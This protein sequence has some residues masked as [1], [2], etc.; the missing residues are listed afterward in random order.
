MQAGFAPIASAIGVAAGVAIVGAGA[1]AI[2]GAGALV[3][4]VQ[5]EEFLKKKP[6][7]NARNPSN[8]DCVMADPAKI[9]PLLDGFRAL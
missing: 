3:G 1:G 7:S 9:Q 6:I 8:N 5:R 2:A 4:W